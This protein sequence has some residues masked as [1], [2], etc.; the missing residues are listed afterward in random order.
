MAGGGTD[1]VSQ[2]TPGTQTT[3][4]KVGERLEISVR[5]WVYF[6]MAFVLPRDAFTM[7]SAGWL[8]LDEPH[9]RLHSDDH[10]PATCKAQLFAVKEAPH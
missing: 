1:G 8:F 2:A 10:R 3:Q 5:Y 7:K 4:R 9:L 6:H